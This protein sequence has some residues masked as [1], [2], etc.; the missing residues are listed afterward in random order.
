MTRVVSV[1]YCTTFMDVLTG[2]AVYRIDTRQC[3]P[4]IH[5]SLS[6][7]RGQTCQHLDRGICSARRTKTITSRLTSGGCHYR[8]E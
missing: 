1:L 7:S 3:K 8:P 4:Q 6:L 2:V 5:L